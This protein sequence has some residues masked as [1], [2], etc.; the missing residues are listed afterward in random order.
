M[1]Q[2]IDNLKRLCCDEIKLKVEYE[3]FE[4]YQ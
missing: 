3:E 4:N 1:C 2:L